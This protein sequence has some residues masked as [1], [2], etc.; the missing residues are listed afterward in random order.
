MTKLTKT[1]INCLRAAARNGGKFE[2]FSSIYWKPVGF[3]PHH[4]DYIPNQIMTFGSRTINA[5]VSLGFLYAGAGK[6]FNEV[7]LTEAGSAAISKPITEDEIGCDHCLN[8]GKLGEDGACPE[9]EA[10]WD[11]EACDLALIKEMRG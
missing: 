11:E 7:W 8:D 9:C 1:Q 4:S 5:L 3:T 2:R 6:T 10:I